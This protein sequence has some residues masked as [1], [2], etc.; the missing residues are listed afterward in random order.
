MPWVLLRSINEALSGRFAKY[1]AAEDPGTIRQGV[2]G[3]DLAIF[4]GKPER[5]WGNAEQPRGLAQVEPRLD[6]VLC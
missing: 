6:P 5:L 1:G 4:G 2:R 3:V